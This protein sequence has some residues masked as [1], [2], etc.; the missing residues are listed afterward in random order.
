VKITDRFRD[1][2]NIESSLEDRKKK[3]MSKY[4][5]A[6]TPSEAISKIWKLDENKN[7]GTGYATDPKYGG[8][9]ETILSMMGVENN[10]EKPE[11]TKNESTP[12]NR[13]REELPTVAIDN[14]KVAP[15]NL[16]DLGTQPFNPNT[17]LTENKLRE[18]LQQ[19]KKVT[20]QRFLDA[21]T[22]KN[23]QQEEYIPEGPV[24][25]VSHLYN[26]IKLI[27]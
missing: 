24:E 21:F 6:S 25:D 17:E 22:S 15:L 23:T 4:E 2:E 16:P 5:N 13:F 3:W 8:K 10:K 7:Q 9:I 11:I 14:T 18:I 20:E 1:Y 27:D 26:Y 19:E 12:V